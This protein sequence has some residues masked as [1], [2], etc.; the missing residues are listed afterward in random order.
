M[1]NKAKTNYRSER[2]DAIIIDIEETMGC[3]IERPMQQ[4]LEQ[5]SIP[6]AN[7]KQAFLNQSGR[8]VTEAQLNAL[9]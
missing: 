4:Y 2:D 8:A 6:K 3:E 5:E 1:Q 7:F 9:I